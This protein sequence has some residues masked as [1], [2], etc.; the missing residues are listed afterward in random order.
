MRQKKVIMKLL[1]FYFL[2]LAS[3]CINGSE[4]RILSIGVEPDLLAQGKFD[5]YAQDASFVG[6]TFEKNTLFRR[7]PK[8]VLMRGSEATESGVLK[9]ISQISKQSKLGDTTIIFFSVHGNLDDKGEF[10]FS[11]APESTSASNWGKLMGKDFNKAISSIKGRILVLLD[12]CEAEGIVKSG[13]AA[14]A[15]Y[16][17]ASKIT[18]SSYG[19]ES[20]EN[21]PH[22]YFVIALCEAINGLADINKDRK[23]TWMELYNYIEH[24][25]CA[26]EP[27]QT[28]CKLL[29]KKHEQFV[30]CQIGRKTKPEFI[31]PEVKS[32]NPFGC[33]DLSKS[34]R[35]SGGKFFR[36]VKFPI[37][38]EDENALSWIRENLEVPNSISGEWAGRWKVDGHAWRV[39]RAWVKLD[40]RRTFILFKGENASYIFE[41]KNSGKNKL[42]GHYMNLHDESDYGPWLG[43]IISNKRIDGFWRDGRWDFRR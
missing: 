38:D 41:A 30:L 32:Q 19:Q 9:Q 33:I 39:G 36:S 26:L 22:G 29:Q 17:M 35:N 31:L 20:N 16:I 12:T 37:Q 27:S 28:A 1:K 15:S 42:L 11:M 18:E 40:G 21:I 25:T 8:I 23:I 43:T 34:A 10:Y 6:Q 14:N 3:L 4:L 2:L 7:T 13:V 5:I 24:R